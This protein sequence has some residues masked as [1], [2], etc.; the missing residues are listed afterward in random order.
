MEKLNTTT[1]FCIFE[2]VLV[3]E[4]KHFDILGQIYPKRVFKVKKR[5]IEHP[6]WILQVRIGPGS[7]FQFKLIILILWTKLAQKGYFRSKTEKSYLY[8]RL[9]EVN[10]QINMTS[11]HSV[12]NNN[13]FKSL[14]NAKGCNMLLTLYQLGEAG[15]FCFSVFW[16]DD[17]NLWGWCEFSFNRK[18]ERTLTINN[19]SRKII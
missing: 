14:L 7:K 18:L 19:I 17:V 1:E 13:S 8:V 12:S 11:N 15:W 9:I 3:S 5:K 6:H 16:K 10:N 2:L 4:F